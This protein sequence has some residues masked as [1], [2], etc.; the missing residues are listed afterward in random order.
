VLCAEQIDIPLRREVE[1][2]SVLAGIP[3][4]ILFQ[5]RAA[6]GTYKHSFLHSCQRAGA[7]L[8]LSLICYLLLLP[9]L[10]L[11]F[12]ACLAAE[13]LRQK[14][15]PCDSKAAAFFLVSQQQSCA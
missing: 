9:Q 13:I 8:L 14:S 6:D 11:E 15:L 2:M 4:F 10:I 1:T 3:E 5:P 12:S 7:P